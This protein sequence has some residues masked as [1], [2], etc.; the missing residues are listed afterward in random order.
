MCNFSLGYISRNYEPLI[1]PLPSSRRLGAGRRIY[2]IDFDCWEWSCE[3][4]GWILRCWPPSAPCCLRGRDVGMELPFTTILGSIR[5]G[6]WYTRSLHVDSSRQEVDQEGATTTI[7]ETIWFISCFKDLFQRHPT[8]KMSPIG[9]SMTMT[10]P[11]LVCAHSG[12][13]TRSLIWQ[14][15]RT[16][17]MFLL[18][19]LDLSSAMGISRNRIPVIRQHNFF[20]GFD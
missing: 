8:S 18:K 1:S 13:N 10:T 7:T 20:V 11:R 9:I 12:W 4:C 5:Y 2:F 14:C 19:V 15:R 16:C 6:R 17:I 3:L